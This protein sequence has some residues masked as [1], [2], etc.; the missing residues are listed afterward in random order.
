MGIKKGTVLTENP[1]KKMI[2]VR[3]VFNME[4]YKK[5]IQELLNLI[6]SEEHIKR[7]YKLAE[8]LYLQEPSE[9]QEITLDL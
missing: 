5:A 2:K 9:T 8:Y 6:A 4:N 3:R 7:I 1:K